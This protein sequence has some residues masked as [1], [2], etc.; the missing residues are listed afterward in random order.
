VEGQIEQRGRECPDGGRRVPSSRTLVLVFVCARQMGVCICV[1][2][3][4]CPVCLCVP[5]CASLCLCA[6]CNIQATSTMSSMN[7][8]LSISSGNFSAQPRGALRRQRAGTRALRCLGVGWSSAAA[9]GC[10]QRIYFAVRSQS[11][12]K[13]HQLPVVTS[14]HADLPAACHPLGLETPAQHACLLARSSSC[15][16]LTRW[17][18]CPLAA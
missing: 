1:P 18:V 7:S 9:G 13:H 15:R 6:R 5:L 16:L 3:Y 2:E 10:R 14:S 11:P 8:T 12:T 4:L 17:S